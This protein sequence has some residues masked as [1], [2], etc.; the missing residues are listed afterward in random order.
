MQIYRVPEGNYELRVSSS[1]YANRCQVSV[2]RRSRSDISCEDARGVSLVA[3]LSRVYFP[4]PSDP[5]KVE[6]VRDDGV[7]VFENR[8]APA[9]QAASNG[10]CARTYVLVRPETI[11]GRDSGEKSQ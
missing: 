9:A 10:W 11:D 6:L 5:F 4:M 1:D 8:S 7:K 2:R 3:E